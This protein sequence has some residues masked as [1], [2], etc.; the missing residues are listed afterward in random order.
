M[1]VLVACEE[2][3]TVCKAFRARGHEAYSC[4]IQDCSG[5]HPEWHIKG[6]VIPLL[7]GRCSFKTV[8]GQEA[9]IPDRWDLLIAHPPCTYLTVSGNR[10]FDERRYGETARQRKKDRDQGAR[11]FLEFVKA[12]CEK[13]AIENPVGAM[14]TIYRPPDQIVQPYYFGH[15]YS[16]TT[17][18]WLKGLPQLIPT[19]VLKRPDGGWEN[20]QITK[21]G[22]YG[23][24][25]GKWGCKS[26]GKWLRYGDPEVKK[27][28][29]KTFVGIAEAMAD[30]WGCGGGQQMM[31]GW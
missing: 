5:G 18:L 20:E 30:Q 4:D 9:A 1:R 14:S 3:Q 16:K 2:S 10:W 25:G 19:N 8:G 15:P 17:C 22:R 21:D 24:Y 28:R 23:G 6:D 11:F 7:N 27:I 12:D 31:E 26:D 29:S 13:I